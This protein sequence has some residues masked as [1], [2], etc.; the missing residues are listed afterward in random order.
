MSNINIRVSTIN[1]AET[2]IRFQNEMAM[3]TEKKTLNEE[4]IKPGV[5]S[6]LTSGNK[7]FY[8]VAEVD[9]S[10]VGSLLITYEWSDWRNAWYWWIQSVYVEKN[11]RRKGVY[12]LLH[13]EVISRCKKSKE[14]CGVRLYVDKENKI[15][16]EVYRKLGMFENNYLLYETNFQ[17]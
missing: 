17:H 1:D 5:K 15:A 12:S 13:N 16:Q 2:I 9:K 14:S 6:V 7:G 4:L 11:W 8:L 10:I 3:E